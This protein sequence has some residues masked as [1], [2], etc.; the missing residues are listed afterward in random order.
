MCKDNESRKIEIEEDVLGQNKLQAERNR[1]WFEAK[2]I[3][4]IN[5][6]SSPGSGKTTILE[7]T[8]KRLKHLN[9]ICVIEG[10][11][12][13][14]NDADRIKATGVNALQINTE[15][16]C[17]LDAFMIKEAVGKMCIPQGAILFIE[18]VGNLVCPAMFDLG[19]KLRVVV[20]SITEGD[21]KPL[22]YPYMFESSDI[23]IINKADLLPYLKSDIE[24]IK[25]NA[26]KINPKLKFFVLSAT[27]GEGMEEWVDFIKV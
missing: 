21:D 16:G 19:E 9:N 5:I 22:K 10:D 20:I 6:V 17:H 18:N 25:R 24:L 27:S 2:D 15:N 14:S 13:T 4:C 7:Q 12:H 8:I 1:G 3:K 26:L 23:C 11:Q